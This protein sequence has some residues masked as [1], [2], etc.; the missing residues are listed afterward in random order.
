MTGRAAHQDQEDPPT[1]PVLMYH[2][3]DPRPGQGEFRPYVV[4]PGL[5]LEHLAAIHQAG[6]EALPIS[7][8]AEG[9]YGPRVVYLTFDDAYETFHRTVLPALAEWDMSATVFAP[10]RFVGLVAGWIRSPDDGARRVA[11][12]ADLRDVVASGSEVGAHGHNHAALD[13]LRTDSIRA[14]LTKSRQ[15]LED[16]LCVSVTTMA[17]PF[18]HSTATVRR[19]ARS[20]GYKIACA[21]AGDLQPVSGDLLRVRRILVS[22]TMS[23]DEVVSAMCGPPRTSVNR[24]LRASVRPAYRCLRGAQ[25][26]RHR[27]GQPDV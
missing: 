24:A 19:E 3:V 26:R 8:L 15:L 4:D 6:Y 14:E 9:H 17:Y 13:L 22:S 7:D 2:D 5:F 25:A 27:I 21:V 1:V 18:G 10:T 20:A 16:G 11:S 12:W 23:A